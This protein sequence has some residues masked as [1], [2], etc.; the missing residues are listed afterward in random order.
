[1]ETNKRGRKNNDIDVAERLQAAYHAIVYKRYSYS[2]FREQFSKEYK[3]TTRQAEL[4]WEQVKKQIQERFKDEQDTL[5]ENQIERYHDLLERARDS[6]N[7]RIEREVLK[8]LTG[9][10]G[11]EQPTK[12]DVTSGG[13]PISLNIILDKE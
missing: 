9:L 7:R 11:L 12:L 4:I 8:D 10:Y 13:L 3:I 2:Q 6:G 1:M 5:L